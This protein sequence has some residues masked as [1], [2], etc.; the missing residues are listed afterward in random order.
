[1]GVFKSERTRFQV[2][3]GNNT[4]NMGAKINPVYSISIYML[5]IFDVSGW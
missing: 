2:T 5:V 3:K 1:M 4:R